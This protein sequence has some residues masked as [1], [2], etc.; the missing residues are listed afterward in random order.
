[1]LPSVGRP[2]L[3]PEAPWKKRF[4]VPRITVSV[5][6]GAPDRVLLSSNR[7]GKFELYAHDLTSGTARQLT[8]RPS[9]TFFGSI[10]DDGRHVFYLNDSQ[11]NETG[12]F[13]R[14]PFGPPETPPQDLTPGLPDYSTFECF[15]DGR[16]T[17]FGFTLPGSEGFDSYLVSMAAQGPGRDP[18]RIHRSP[19]LAGGPMLSADG[20]RAVVATCEKQGGLDFG[21]I[22]FDCATGQRMREL[23][24]ASSSVEPV[25]FSPL[26]GDS[27]LLA[28]ST[29]S[30]PRR[31]IIWDASAGDRVDLEVGSMEGDIEPLAWSPDARR[32]LLS[33]LSRATQRLYLYDLQESSVL[34]F[35]HPAGSFDS[36]C[37]R[38]S[39]ILLRWQK[40]T[41]APQLIAI[42]PTRGS[43]RILIQE[44]ESPKGRAWSSVMF[45]SSDGEEVQGWV[46]LPEGTGPFPTI[47][48]THGGPTA[49]QRDTFSPSSQMWLDHGFAYATI[50]YRGSTT[51]GKEFEKK[52]YGDLGHWEVEDMMAARDWLVQTGVARSDAI[53]LTGWSYGGYLTLQAMGL[54][55]GVWAGGM[56][57]VVVADW[58]TQFED[59]SE[60]LRGYDLAL[61]GGPPSEKRASYEKASPIFY[62]ENVTAPILII[63]GRNDTRDPPR[64]VE[65]YETK[66][67]ALGKEVRV[68]WFDTGHTGPFVDV[69][70]SVAQHETMLRFAYEV[71]SR[72]L[73]ATTHPGN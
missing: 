42:E 35:D 70:L 37:F 71:M 38:G 44:E 4:R 27:R 47:L 68:E 26:E 20:T 15:A 62:L 49:V 61:F 56:G 57:G 31:P 45:R 53:F 43:T 73:G 25:A 48:E 39:E 28:T 72:P 41:T 40:S 54:K 9:G 16:S 22:S 58:I 24:L 5:A 21:V 33:Q 2:I 64:Q 63:Q 34:R 55:P 65:L 50:N 14:I 7:S 17:Q 67:R 29:E 66:A 11:G 8:N 69:G 18:R 32:V 46:A 6:R 59:E 12:H 3:G 1:M 36:A 23:S 30:G 10:S 51:F 52:I 19:K 60:T 13:V